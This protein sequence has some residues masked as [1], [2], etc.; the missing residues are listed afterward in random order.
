MIYPP[1][2]MDFRQHQNDIT[3]MENTTQKK[4]FTTVTCGMHSCGRGGSPNVF[5][6]W[7]FHPDQEFQ[8]HH[9]SPGPYFSTQKPLVWYS[10]FWFQIRKEN[11]PQ[12]QNRH[13]FIAEI[14]SPKK[15]TERIVLTWKKTME[16]HVTSD[17]FPPL[18]CVP[19]GKHTSSINGTN[20]RTPPPNK[21]NGK[22]N[23]ILQ[24]EPCFWL[25][26]QTWLRDVI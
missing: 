4:P 9:P 21:K 16:N 6:R 23:G 3:D 14:R 10:F 7:P 1:A 5:V 18:C 11:N 12:Q 25:K 19:P 2:R 20:H 15:N 22:K 13:L 26:D 24:A 8:A 17:S